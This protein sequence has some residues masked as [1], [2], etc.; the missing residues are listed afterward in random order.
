M[1]GHQGNV[2]APACLAPF[3]ASGRHVRTGNGGVE[4][5]NEMR[6]FAGGGKVVEHGLEYAGLAEAREA[7]PHRLLV[8]GE[9]AS[10]IGGDRNAS[11]RVMR[12]VRSRRASRRAIAVA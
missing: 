9:V 10:T 2:Q 12:T 7:F 6:A 8:P 5:L 11:V 3:G 1:R 4:Q